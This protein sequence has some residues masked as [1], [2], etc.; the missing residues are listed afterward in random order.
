MRLRKSPSLIV[1]CVVLSMASCMVRAQQAAKPALEF[2]AASVR[3]NQNPSPRPGPT[4]VPLDTE[5]AFVPTGGL[6]SAKGFPLSNY[7]AFAYRQQNSPALREQLPKWAQTARFDIEARAAGNP[8]KNQYREMMRSLLAQRF[9]L[10]VHTETRQIRIYAMVLAKPGQPGPQ[11][12]AHAAGADCSGSPTITSMGGIF[13]SPPK[14]AILT[15]PVTLVGVF[16]SFCGGFVGG[17]PVDPE[18]SPGLF[19]AGGRGMSMEL[20]ADVFTQR[21]PSNNLGE[22]PILDRTGLTGQYDFIVEWTSSS[23][24]STSTGPTTSMEAALK[25]QLGLKLEP[26]EAPVDV[27]LIDHLEQPTEN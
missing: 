21:G 25:D 22:R 23:F 27:L 2:E 16:P 13:E 4:N 5:D 24:A 1:V 15:K 7:I 11:L 8:T 17:V 9:K 26:T 3:E 10:Q 6:F 19:M 12:R 20:I 14:G 18:K